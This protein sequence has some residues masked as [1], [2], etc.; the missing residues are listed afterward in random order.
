MLQLKGITK[1]YRSGELTQKALNEISVNFRESEFVAVL[2]P[3]G[4]GKTTLLNIIGGLDRYDSGDLVIRGKSTKEYKDA[5][6]DAYR[7]HSVGFVFQTYN[8]IPHQNA[9]SNVELALTLSG[10]PKGERKRRAK[11]VLCKVGLADQLHKKPNQMSG[12]QMQ[13]VAIARA[14]VNNP[15]IL[16]ADEPTGALDSETSGQVIDILKEISADKLI[17]M[18][19]HNAEIAEKYATRIIR[20]KDGEITDDSRPFTD[21]DLASSEESGEA[22]TKPARR[23][24]KKEKTSMSFFTALS[25]S[26]NNLLTKK[27]RTVLTSFAGSIGIIGIALIVALSSG[28]Q[29]YIDSVQA[30][31][32]SSYPLAIESSAMDLSALMGQRR[33]ENNKEKVT[34]SDG[35]IHSNTDLIDSL[36]ARYENTW[37]N[38]LKDFKVYLDSKKDELAASVNA[39]EYNYGVTLHIYAPDTSNGINQLNPSPL[40][41]DLENG[42]PFGGSTK[43]WDELI[44]NSKLLESQYDVL[45]GG[46]PK[47]YN[48]VVVIVDADNG[49]DEQTLMALGIKD[50]AAVMEAIDNNEA[51][52][53][54]QTTFTYDEIM[55]RTFK[56]VL[57]P[58]YYSFDEASGTWVDKSGDEAYVM[59]LI[60]KGTP[61]KVAGIVKPSGQSVKKESGSSIGYLK[62]LTEYVVNETGKREIVKQQLAKPDTDIFKNL[63]FE[64]ASKEEKTQMQ[65]QE[66]VTT[67]PAENTTA[68]AGTAASF[69]APAAGNLSFHGSVP[70]AAYMESTSVPPEAM[71]EE[72]IYA[73]IKANYTADEQEKLLDFAKLFLKNT[74]TFSERNRLIAYLDAILEERQMEGMG[75]ITGQQAYAY[76]Q[77]MDKQTKLQLLTGII[78]GGNKP[79][80]TTT[81]QT[82]PG[83]TVP[84][85]TRPGNE[86]PSTQP[87]T[88]P[89]TE[90]VTEPVTQP[91]PTVSKSS[92]EKNLERL[93]VADLATP[94][95]INIYPKSFEAK[96]ALVQFIKDYNDQMKARGK[97]ENVIEYTDYIGLI[98][99]SVTK[100]VNIVS[101]VLIAF[102]SISLVVSSIMIGIIT[103]ISVLERTKEIGILRSIGASKR[104]ISRVFNAE[105][106]II[107]F[108]A[109]LM[110]IAATLLLCIPL[111]M[112]IEKLADI[113]DV[114]ELPVIGGVLLIGIS[115][116]L[117]TI[118]GL[119]PARMAANK[120]PVVALRTE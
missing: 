33:K 27:G 99:S 102:V 66:E 87:V 19:T 40:S 31:M 25:L 8:L 80:E 50:A 35:K 98:M 5:H 115:I 26:L 10:V 3:S 63:P 53:P 74:R 95:S 44:D 75:N 48:E 67:A 46:W 59:N 55:A 104:D 119:I 83:T 76:I 97:D 39:I 41:N 34:Y 120:D 89:A 2:G 45:A 70:A 11:D 106:L 38:N 100:I 24:R 72:E 51:Y 109:G 13:R 69:P 64:A 56:L 85:T 43:M 113:A 86:E 42:S 92:L 18:V 114:A 1:T 93:G 73:Y 77:M 54:G 82:E 14:L 6:W 116:V 47:A 61:L 96:D 103:Y 71:T 118:A 117:T 94:K 21:E 23:K 30:D 52:D 84:A 16:L 9:L 12:G 78:R 81:P 101:Y 36:N 15:D 112:I 88:E 108:V 37:E 110:G 28:F 62:S 79:E 4:S 29:A 91:G 60:D 20:L 57:Q 105:T 58:D 90:P 17:I 68:A 107:G 65:P 111:N 32:L 22:R 49:I 7:N